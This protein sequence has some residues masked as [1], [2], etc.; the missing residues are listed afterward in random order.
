MMDAVA[1]NSCSRLKRP[2]VVAFHFES[3]LYAYHSLASHMHGGTD[4]RLGVSDPSKL[5]ATCRRWAAFALL[6]TLRCIT[7]AT[8]QSH[9]PSHASVYCI[10][11]TKVSAQSFKGHARTQ[12]RCHILGPNHMMWQARRNDLGD[13]S[14]MSRSYLAHSLG[15]QACVEA[16][17]PDAVSEDSSARMQCTKYALYS[18]P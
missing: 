17:A 6:T 2:I 15:A 14:Y 7:C 4:G 10:S 13:I 18:A 9:T 12:Q 1:P 8:S 5:S 16:G 11:L 3:W